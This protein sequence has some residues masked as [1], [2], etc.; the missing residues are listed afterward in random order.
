M[1]EFNLKV[2]GLKEFER[3]I[4]RSP[5][6][7]RKELQKFFVR[8]EAKIKSRLRN[9]PWQLG[10]SGGGVPVLT[11]NLRDGMIGAGRAPLAELGNRRKDGVGHIY[12]R[13]AT[14]LR[15]YPTASYAKYVHDGTGRM[16]GRPWLDHALKKEDSSIK[17]LENDL[18]KNIVSNLA[19]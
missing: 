6:N 10:Q 14:R 4:K 17:K 13:T 12:E 5:E 15:I 7:T 1:A 9:R 18:L 11:G 16:K 8:A 2:V 19:S 3:A